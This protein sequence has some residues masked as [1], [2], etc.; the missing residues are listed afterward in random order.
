M[1]KCNRILCYII[2]FKRDRRTW[3][4]TSHQLHWIT[5][6]DSK[7]KNTNSTVKELS[8]MNRQ[9]RSLINYL[10]SRK[11]QHNH[12]VPSLNGKMMRPT[13]SNMASLPSWLRTL[14]LLK[15]LMTKTGLKLPK[16]SPLKMPRSVT[17]DGCSFRNS[18]VTRS[19]GTHKKTR[20]SSSSLSSMEPKTGQVFLRSLMIRWLICNRPPATSTKCKSLLETASSAV[21]DG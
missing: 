2:K 18:E 5:S 15:T 8:Q 6:S 12:C 1:M 10:R 9:W 20:S 21:K 7:T 11:I 19:S 14:N 4:A 16:S 17:R 13:S 3:E